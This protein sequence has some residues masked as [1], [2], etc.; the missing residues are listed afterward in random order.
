MF[1]AADGRIYS[2]MFPVHSLPSNDL[3]SLCASLL[4][5]F[6][7][8]PF[9]LS[10][11]P[12]LI[13]VSLQ[14]VPFRGELVGGLGVGRSVTVRGETNQNAE[15]YMMSHKCVFYTDEGRASKRSNSVSMCL[16]FCIN[17][18]VSG[19]S[20]IALHLNPRLKKGVF[21]RNSFLCERWG[22]EET[23]GG[24]TPFAAGRYFEVWRLTPN[25]HCKRKRH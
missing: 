10:F 2:C 6:L 23:S 7:L 1:V 17:L 3:T 11:L 15:R 20:D 9:F 12:F 21:V 19:G 24:P 8:P 13:L 22:P 18:R 16:S 14:R 25:F 5:S 4:L